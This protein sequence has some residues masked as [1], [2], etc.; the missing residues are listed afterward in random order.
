MIAHAGPYFN[1][2]SGFGDG[3]E[4]GIKGGSQNI[5][6]EGYLNLAKPWGINEL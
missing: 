2:N 5:P 4:G 3:E 6:K 1:L